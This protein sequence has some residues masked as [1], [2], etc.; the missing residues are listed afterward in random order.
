MK[1]MKYNSI[2][3]N[4]DQEQQCLSQCNIRM[5]TDRMTKVKP[6]KSPAHYV[7]WETVI[8][9]FVFFSTV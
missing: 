6:R 7:K 3:F 4:Y 9:Y 5:E 8:L 1:K 2:K